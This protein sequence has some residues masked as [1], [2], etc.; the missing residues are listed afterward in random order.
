MLQQSVRLR[1][2]ELDL[3]WLA[4]QQEEKEVPRLRNRPLLFVSRCHFRSFGS[5]FRLS[6]GRKQNSRCL[7]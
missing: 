3:A 4:V 6:R 2:D 1:A 7:M 5:W